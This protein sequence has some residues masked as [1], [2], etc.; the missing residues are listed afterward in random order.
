MN[1]VYVCIEESPDYGKDAVGVYDNEESA[2][3][4]IRQKFLE[5]KNEDPK[6]ESAQD[7]DNYSWGDEEC[8][9]I[10]D[11]LIGEVKGGH[12]WYCYYELESYGW[13]VFKLPV[14]K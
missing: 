13:Y 12:K 3:E 7:N 4:W 1:E 11:R 5:F 9:G 8:D 2:R 10:L 6:N 14:M